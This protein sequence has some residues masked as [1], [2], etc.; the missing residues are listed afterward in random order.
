MGNR[1]KFKYPSYLLIF[2][3]CSGL[4][5]ASEKIL[6]QVQLFQGMWSEGRHCL[7]QIEILSKSTHPELSFF[8]DTGI[9][10]ETALT[11]AVITALLDIYDFQTI[12]DWFF[13]EKPWN[14]LGKPL[15]DDLVLGDPTSFQIKLKPQKLPSQK[16]SLH[17]VISS[18]KINRANLGGNLETIID[19]ELVLEMGDPVIVSVPCQSGAYF[20][21]V[22]LTTGS[23]QEQKPSSKKSEK[24]SLVAAPKPIR[25][26]QPFYP[27]ALRRHRIGGK[28]GL[29]IT[30]D[31]KG[32]AQWIEVVRPLHPYLNY[33]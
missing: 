14:G 17:A 19:Q 6:I 23:P 11:A 29:L 5:S 22:N 10:S 25:Q 12:D 18:G 9:G 8:K 4:V 13:H 7:K 16:I 24:I 32:I 3:F 31:E 1:L 20:M 30:I 2:I 28:I 33:S 21:M 15:L 26:V 27:E